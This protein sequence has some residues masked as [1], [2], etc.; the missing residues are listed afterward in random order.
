[1]QNFLHIRLKVSVER[2]FGKAPITKSDMELLSSQIFQKTGHIIS[3]NTLRR[4]FGTVKSTKT[5][6]SIKDF[7]SQY[8][9]YASFHEFEILNLP[10][11]NFINWN[12]ISE[13][14]DIDE[15]LFMELKQN[16]LIKDPV[17]LSNLFYV[18]QK[19]V[20]IK[21]VEQWAYF[22]YCLNLNSKI[23]EENTIL[24]LMANMIG[25]YLRQNEFSELEL[26]FLINN[27]VIRENLIH[28][29]V[30]YKSLF[31][32]GFYSKLL[33]QYSPVKSEEVV[34]KYSLL[35]LKFFF[36]KKNHQALDCIEIVEAIK[37]KNEFFPIINGRIEAAFILREIIEKNTISESTLIHVL[38]RLKA[39]EGN[40]VIPYSMEILPLLVQYASLSKILED[41][42]NHVGKFDDFH[43][44]WN[45]NLDITMYFVSRYIYHRRLNESTK[46]FLYLN[47]IK[48]DSLLLY[49]REYVNVLLG[50]Y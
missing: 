5:S 6:G 1:M 24:L 33:D 38:E 19:F 31:E 13:F 8:C 11:F 30:D 37:P 40:N 4:F 49:Y 27:Q 50:K 17:A 28:N 15:K 44:S 43:H 32:G 16:S 10:D 46:A 2:Q 47:L 41:I 39:Q 35:A 42:L 7:L 12:R 45:L 36:Q 3:Y 34:F 9:G 23:K 21:P 29:F 48:N 20:A 25:E 18:F 26:G 14:G 22:Y